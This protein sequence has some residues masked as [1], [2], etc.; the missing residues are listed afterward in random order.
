MQINVCTR[1]YLLRSSGNNTAQP[2]LTTGAATPGALVQKAVRVMKL[3]AFF[4]LATCL[5]VNATDGFGQKVTLSEREVHVE[6]IFNEIKKQTGFNFLYTSNILANTHRVTVNVTNALVTEVLDMVVAGQGL[7][8]RVKGEDRLIIIKTKPPVK[9]VAEAEVKGG[10]PIDVSGRVTDNEGRPLPGANVK[11]KGTNIGV[12]TDANGHFILRNIEENASLEISFVGH[13][14]QTITVR[15]KSLFNIVLNQKN[16]LLDETVVIAY[17]TTTRRFTTGNVSTI[18][19]NDIEKQPVNNP[20]LALQ[21][22]VPGIF[23]Q[24]ASGVPGSGVVVRIQG[25]NSITKGNDPLY[26]VDGVPYP[27][28]VLENLGGAILGRSGEVASGN[29]FSYI[30]PNDIES[31]DVL[32]DADATAIYGSRAANG[33]ILITT[34]RGKSGQTRVNVNFQNGWGKVARKL[35]LLNTEQYLKMRQEAYLNDGLPI[36][37]PSSAPSNSNYDLTLWDQSRY[38]DWQKVLI[39]GTSK[40]L[41]A[42]ASASGG[43]S[44]TQFMFGAGYHRETTVFPGDLSDKKASI[45]FNINTTSSNQRFRLQ[46]TGNYLEDNSLLMGTDLAG[47]AFRLAPNAPALY[48][49]DGAL[50][51]APR[52]NGNSTWTNP[53]TYLLQRYKSKTNNLVGNAVISYQL[54]AGLDIRTSFGYTNM[55]T[56]ESFI[57][58]LVAIRPELRPFSNRASQFVDNSISSWVVEPQLGYKKNFSNQKLECLIGVTVLQNNSNGLQFLASGF[59]SDNVLENIKSAANVSIGSATTSTFRYN[60]LFGNLNYNLKEKYILNFTARKDGSSRFGSENLFHVFYGIGGGWIFSNEDVV[61]KSLRFLTFG[62]LRISYGT[63]GSDNIGDY[64]FMS[65]YSPTSAGVAYQGTTGL[66]V[67]GI[68]NPFLQWEETRKFNLGLDVGLLADRILFT[69]NHYRNRS[70]NQLLSYVLPSITGVA[71]ITRNFPATLQN[72][73]WEFSINSE[74]V[75]T[76]SFSWTNSINFTSP[77]NEL[78]AF[79]DLATSP[80]AGTL[81]I[82]KPITLIRVLHYMGVDPA[83]GIY[84][85]QDINGNATSSPSLATDQLTLINTAPAFYGGIQNNIKYKDFELTFLFQFVKQ[86]GSHSIFGDRPGFF[87]GTGNLGNQPTTV[88][89][90]WQKPGDVSQNQQ[91]TAS[92]FNIT[93]PAIYVASSDAVWSDA[94]YLRLKNLSLSW[95]LPELLRKKLRLQ[96]C[97][98]YTQGQNLLTITGYNG[99]DPENKSSYSLPPLRLFTIG[100]QVG[101]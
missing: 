63:T 39:G 70:S 30:N 12:V 100:I 94:S 45:H 79:P 10:G 101:F 32:K 55:Q 99:L 9:T 11:V 6:K 90:R 66:T 50:N 52:S 88:L 49:E 19:A 21:G 85:F 36:P 17:G 27:S 3:T 37:N 81:T 16:S 54:M 60:A 29:P 26:V 1:W 73:G 18:K 93:L 28:Q 65:L 8:Y 4:I 57:V 68:P 77:K 40:Y 47:P 86:K 13:D 5:H 75:K 22:R 24:Q 58:P 96:S 89:Q 59:N 91:Y 95:Q 42:Q 92:K 44:N 43:T 98:L 67:N 2:K 61:K 97:K 87:S 20:L 53:L 83:K 41:D 74:I 71:E 38:T 14:V 15:G 31:I 23:I 34:K 64:Q 84:Q 48:K 56:R 69:I 78:V 72:T 35:D 46:V 62:K 25:Q 80:Y 51:W 82:G 7:E 33:A 76:K